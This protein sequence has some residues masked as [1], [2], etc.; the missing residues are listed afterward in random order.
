MTEAGTGTPGAM[1]RTPR[2][3][4]ALLF[5]SLAVNLLIIGS[6]A[7]AMWRFRGPPPWASIVIPN[8]IGYASTLPLERRKQLWAL[9]ADERSHVRPFRRQVRAAR[10]ETTK[11]LGAQPF[12]RQRFIEAQTRQSEIENHARAAVLP[13]YAKIAEI[14]TPEERQAFSHWREK[15]RGPVRNL[16]DEPDHQASEPAPK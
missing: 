10:A 13:L 4:L 1:R 12:D 16:L 6:V 8:L 5:V 14:L 7:G 3:L 11:A 15:R 9:T 2:W